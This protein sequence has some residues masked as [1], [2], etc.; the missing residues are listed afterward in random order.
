ML[1]APAAWRVPPFP[2]RPRRGG[3]RFSRRAR[4]VAGSAFPDAPA[5]WRVPLFPT[6]LLRILLA[7]LAFGCASPYHFCA[8]PYHLVHGVLAGLALQRQAELAA[9]GDAPLR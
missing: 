3:F 9:D 8:S 5:A 2:T 6:R 1:A 4:G 7:R